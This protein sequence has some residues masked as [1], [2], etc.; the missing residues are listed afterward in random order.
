MNPF[1][2]AIP[3]GI[4]NLAIRF[5]YTRSATANT[6][7]VTNVGNI[8]ILDEYRKYIKG[9]TANIAMSIGQDIKGTILSYGDDFVY[10]FS[11][12]LED[13]SIERTFV[14]QL[15]ADGVKVSVTTNGVFYG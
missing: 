6:T 11:T 14:K 4:K 5:V 1:L 9:F 7:T 3:L 13:T 2:K 15:A 8:K 12:N 10:T